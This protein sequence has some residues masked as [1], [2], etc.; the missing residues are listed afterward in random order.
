MEK[1]E[2]TDEDSNDSDEENEEF[3]CKKRKMK[4][5]LSMEEKKAK[6]E[7]YLNCKLKYPKSQFCFFYF[8]GTCLLGNKCQF[9]HG[10]EEFSTDRYFTILQDKEAIEK[11]SQKYYQKFYFS[12]IIPSDEYNY[13]NLLEFQDKYPNLFKKKYTF[14]EL[15]KSRKKRL[16]IRELLTKNII[17]KFLS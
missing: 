4:F 13:D 8:K 15:K 6:Y 7:T 9:C 17:E 10:Y 11:S 5:D 12:E 1:I 3:S 14:K 16:L 2:K